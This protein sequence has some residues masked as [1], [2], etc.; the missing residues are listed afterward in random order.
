MKKKNDQEFLWAAE[1][2]E[3]E[4][5]KRFLDKDVMK[6][7]VADVTAKGLDQWTALH[8]AADQGHLD[9]LLEVIKQPGVQFDSQSS[10]N[11]TPLHL[12]AIKGHSEIGRELVKYG[13]DANA[14]DIDESTPLHC[15]SEFGQTNFIVFLLQEA[16]ADH[17]LKNKFGS[18]ATDI[19]QNLDTRK[20]FEQFTDSSTKYARTAYNG[21]LLHN[22][23]INQVQRLMNKTQNVNK[24]MN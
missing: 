17:T 15:A 18:Q 2:G 22:D 13:A 24:F 7:M 5:L 23:R 10:N 12:A 19:A 20:A 11:R 6:D 14:K 9:I 21:V 1:S 8:F 16:K 3:L 4:N